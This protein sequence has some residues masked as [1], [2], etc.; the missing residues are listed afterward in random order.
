MRAVRF[1]LGWVRG[2]FW[3]L[4]LAW[5]GLHGGW[6]REERGACGCSCGCSCVAGG[7]NN[8][9]RLSKN[10]IP[11]VGEGVKLEVAR[12]GFFVVFDSIAR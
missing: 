8:L 2:L 3:G 4:F 6:V 7:D 5:L 9:V 12:R 11:L 1:G 10:R